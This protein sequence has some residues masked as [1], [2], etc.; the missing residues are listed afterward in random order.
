MVNAPSTYDYDRNSIGINTI[1]T[2]PYRYYI[3]IAYHYYNIYNITRPTVSISGFRQ[4]FSRPDIFVSRT[5]RIFAPKLFTAGTPK[6]MEKSSA[7]AVRIFIGS[8]AIAGQ[9]IRSIRRPT[10]DVPRMDYPE[11][12]S[13]S[14]YIIYIYIDER[15][16]IER[17]L[18]S[19]RRQRAS[20]ITGV[21]RT[22]AR[23]G[24]RR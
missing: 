15:R 7:T 24:A 23:T 14:H 9:S 12:H 18:A 4:S 17:I 10:V 1:A 16:P 2:A 20:G 8:S 13:S 19:S 3:I 21:N 5:A 22:S 6:L 11:I